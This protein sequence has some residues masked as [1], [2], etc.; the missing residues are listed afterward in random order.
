MLLLFLFVF[1][2]LVDLVGKKNYIDVHFLCK[3]QLGCL[4]VLSESRF[5]ARFS[6]FTG[7]GTG[8]GSYLADPL[9]R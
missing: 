2:T 1:F 8:T 4:A 6:C 9:R 7:M 5:D 3:R